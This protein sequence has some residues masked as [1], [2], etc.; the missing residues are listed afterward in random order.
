MRILI[1]ALI[2]LMASAALAQYLRPPIGPG[3]SLPIGPISSVSGG[4]GG[5]GGG[6]CTGS[7]IGNEL[8]WN[9]NTGCNLVWAG[10]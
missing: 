3:S 8:A 4:G 7:G 9:D 1:A 10:H 2:V 5:G 6:G